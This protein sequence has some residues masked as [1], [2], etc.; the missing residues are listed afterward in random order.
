MADF[1]A[2][3]L[4]FNAMSESTSEI[5]TLC[6]SLERKSDAYISGKGGARRGAVQDRRGDDRTAL[7]T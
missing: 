4:N 7:F 1:S 6:V 3:G 2:E 5:F